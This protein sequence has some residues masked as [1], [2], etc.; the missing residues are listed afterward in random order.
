MN[1]EHIPVLLGHVIDNLVGAGSR[2]FIDATIGGGGH[3]YHILERYKDIRVIGI[4]ID[5]DALE[6]AQRRLWLFKDRVTLVRG[7]FR[8]LK[9]ILKTRGVSSFDAILFDLG[10][11]TYQL[12]GNRGFSFHSEGPLD[13]RMDQREKLTAYDVVNRY[14]YGMLYSILKNFGEEKKASRIARMIVEERKKKPIATAE[15]LSSVVCKV[16][17]RRGRIHPA[18]QTFQAIRMEVNNELHNIEAGIHGA[19]DMLLPGGRIGV[20]SFHSLEDRLVKNIFRNSPGLLIHTKKPIAPDMVEVRNN[21]RAR[22][23]KLRIAEKI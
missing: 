17:K 7:N 23:A 10:L 11:S 5:K 1:G 15:A 12:M 9:A 3:A 6:I 16:K 4:D 13:M 21:P 14:T 22:S 2:L 20:I 8:D 18:T 19:I